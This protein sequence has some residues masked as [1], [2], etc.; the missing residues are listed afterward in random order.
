MG[1]GTENEYLSEGLH[2]RVKLVD[3]T[4]CAI[5]S[6]NRFQRV[7]KDCMLRKRYNGVPDHMFSHDEIRILAMYVIVD[8]IVDEH[9]SFIGK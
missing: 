4:G 8:E 5:R 2:K 6:W 7:H 9:L 1:K 3:A